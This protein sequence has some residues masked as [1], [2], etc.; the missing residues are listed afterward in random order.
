MN[1]EKASFEISVSVEDDEFEERKINCM[2]DNLERVKNS[3][4]EVF[5]P[6]NYEGLVNYAAKLFIEN[7]LLRNERQ[8]FVN[9]MF[10]LE[11]ATAADDQKAREQIK[12]AF[13]ENLLFKQVTKKMSLD[14]QF[15]TWGSQRVR[16]KNNYFY[17]DLVI[18]EWKKEPSRFPSADNAGGHFV[19]WLRNN[20]KVEYQQRTVSKWIRIYAKTHGIKLR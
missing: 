7:S 14:K 12:A 11:F 9:A 1:G 17:R 4:K 18:N 19:D 8:D 13:K 10:G 6:S 20:H 15:T 2:K 3:V 5:P 16:H